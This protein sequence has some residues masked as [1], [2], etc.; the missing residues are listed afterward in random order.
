MT[1][2]LPYLDRCRD[3]GR[4]SA[5]WTDGTHEDPRPLG[6]TCGNPARCG[7]RMHGFH[8]QV[9]DDLVDLLAELAVEGWP[10]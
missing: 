2:S 3:C 10:A 6:Q 4:L 1:Y 5:I 7:E 8:A 9:D